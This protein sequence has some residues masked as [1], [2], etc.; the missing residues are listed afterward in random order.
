MRE[1]FRKLATHIS[2]G[3]GS[4]LTFILA[5]SIVIFWLIIG[6]LFNYSDTWQLIISTTTNVIALLIL[7]I[8][9]YTQNRDSRAIHLK[10]DE[11]IKALKGARTGLVDIE[12][13]SDADLDSLQAEFKAL[14]EKYYSELHKRKKS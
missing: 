8:V 12:D 4:P 13:L 11:L 14:H 1:H 10:L 5:F 7:F 6:S 2:N 9:Q 3:I